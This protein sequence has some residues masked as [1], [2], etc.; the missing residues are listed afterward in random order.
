VA[1][2]DNSILPDAGGWSDQAASFVAAFPIVQSE[3]AKA[4]EKAIERA[5]PK[6]P[7]R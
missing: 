1:L 5:K 6:P 2:V 3:I 4:R 7:K